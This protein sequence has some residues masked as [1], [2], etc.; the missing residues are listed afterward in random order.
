MLLLLGRLTIN[1]DVM[2]EYEA[3]V[4]AMSPKVLKEDGCAY[5]S[6][7]V[8]DKTAGV[9]A[10]A[11]LWR[12]EAALLHHFTQPWILDFLTKFQSHVVDSTIRAYDAENE[13]DLPGG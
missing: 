8:E 5:Y 4:A 11:E 1:P 6:L 12:D 7:T 10:V 9:V 13:R 2:D 3:A